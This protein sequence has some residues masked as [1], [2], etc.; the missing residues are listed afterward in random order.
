MLTGLIAPDNGTAIV[1][2]LDIRTDLAGV[3]RSLGVCPQ[4]DVVGIIFIYSFTWFFR[5]L[6]SL[7]V[8]EQAAYY[9]YFLIVIAL[10]RRFLL[11]SSSPISQ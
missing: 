10:I 3:R 9:Y 2:G 8:V 7:L 11:C 5:L 1:D 4:H 6:L